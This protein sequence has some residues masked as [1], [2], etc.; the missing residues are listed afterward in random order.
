MKIEECYVSISV[1][2]ET[3][4][5]MPLEDYLDNQAMKYGYEDYNDLRTCGM[6][7]DFPE[8]YDKNKNKLTENEVILIKM[9]DCNK[10]SK[11]DFS[12]YMNPPVN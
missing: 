5:L 11:D 9:Q 1:E 2:N 10:Y 4:Y 3:S 8:L 7:I 12:Q 6:S